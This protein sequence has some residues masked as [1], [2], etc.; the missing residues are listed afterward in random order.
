MVNHKHEILALYHRGL[1]LEQI[2]QR[3]NL[4]LV[5]V[6]IEVASADPTGEA[7]ESSTAKSELRQT[8][9]AAGSHGE[10]MLGTEGD[11][12]KA[13]YWNPTQVNNPHLL[14]VG[15][16]GSGK[17]Y[18]IQCILLELLKRQIPAIIIDYGQG[19]NLETAEPEF[20]EVARIQELQVGRDG[21]KLNPLEIRSA[22]INGP[23]NVAARVAG[24]FRRIYSNLGEQQHN[25]LM[26]AILE[27]FR[28]RGIH[29]EQPST[30]TRTPPYMDDLK[31]VLEE[32]A[33]DPD[34]PSRGTATTL[35]SHLGTFFM[36]RTFRMDGLPLSWEERLREAG[37]TII[38]L[39]GLDGEVPKVV[40]EF[41]L[42]DLFSFFESIGPAKGLRLF[43]VLDE[44]HNLDFGRDTPVDKI[45]RESRKYGLGLILASQHPK[46]FGESAFANTASKLVF[47]VDD[48]GGKLA[49][50]LSKS[51]V[52]VDR[53]TAGDIIS[54]LQKGQAL[55]VSD[56]K[57][58]VCRI[59]SLSHR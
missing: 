51:L 28:R 47:F 43:A 6:A 33:A 4:S 2:S 13:V 41:L 15:Q 10:I 53:K 44:A 39:K 16:S 9:D 58:I 59:V 31:T 1:S 5:D 17:T 37:V 54:S 30:W 20:R 18:S 55:F 56:K 34:N 29:P 52:G 48:E 11:S 32:M 12:N 14:V 23:K 40:T 49:A 24:T 26:E 25:V 27:C 57:G 21:L 3:L 50:R 46:D 36:Y 8:V 7:R 42:W 35:R 19:F 45:V 38:Q 22:D